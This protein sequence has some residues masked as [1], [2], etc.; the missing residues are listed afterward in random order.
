MREIQIEFMGRHVRTFGQEAHVAERA[1]VDHGLEIGTVDRIELARFRLVDQVEQTGEA[2]AQI[3]AAPASMT[4]IEHPAQFG[5]ELFLI[6][7]IGVLPGNHVADRGFQAAFAHVMSFS[8]GPGK[9]GRRI[10][11]DALP[12][13]KAV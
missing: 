1:G 4:D 3:E 6:V 8:C 5:V 11:R 12:P 2:V 10:D 9:P 7:E 13:P